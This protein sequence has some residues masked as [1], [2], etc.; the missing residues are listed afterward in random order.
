MKNQRLPLVLL[1]V[2]T[3]PYFF[4]QKKTP[5]Y[6]EYFLEGSYL[7][8]EDE[9]DLALTNFKKAYRLDSS[10]ANINYMMG[11]ACLLSQKNK[12]DAEY[13]L[14]K[15]VLAVSGKYKADDPSEKGAPPLSQFYFG[16]ALHFN[17]KF[18]EAMKA[19]EAFRPSVNPK[20]LEYVKML[21]HAELATT[22]AKDLTNFPLN[23]KIKN[24]GKAVNSP[25]PEYS[26]VLSADERTLIYTTRRP[27]FSPL[28]DR[29][30][31]N[32]ED[33][34]VSY[35]DDEGNWSQPVTLGINTMGHEACINLSADGQT[36]LIY[37]NEAT[38]KNP[39]GNGNIYYAEYNGRDWAELKEFGSDVN[40]I[41][42][43]SHA[44]LSADGNLLF[45]SSERPGGYGGKDIYRCIKL[46]NGKWSKA[47]NMGPR[48]N[49]EFDEDGGFIHPD[50]QTFFY[51]SNGPGSMGGYDILYA[52]L[53]EDNKFGN[54]VNMGYPINT[55]DDDIFFVVSPD[56]KRG[57]FASFK[58][59][60][61]G[62]KDLYEIELDEKREV[63]LAVFKGQI[64]AAPGEALP[65]NIIIQVRDK[66][67]GELTGVYRPRAQN[68]TFT[69]IL[70][71]GHEYSF[72]YQLND[73]EEFYREELYVS[74]EYAYQEYKREVNL[75]PVKI[76][77][78]VKVL[79][80]TVK[81]TI[82]VLDDVLNKK[83]VF[84]ARVLLTDASGGRQVFTSNAKGMTEYA[85]LAVDKAYAISADLE[86]QHSDTLKFT[87]RNSKVAEKLTT[88]IYLNKKQAAQSSSEHVLNLFVQNS[89]TKKG[90][91]HV[92]IRLVDE[93]G[94]KRELSGDSTGRCF[95]I[96]LIAGARYKLLVYK[97]NIAAEEEVF[98]APK[99]AGVI[100]KTLTLNYPSHR[101]EPYLEDKEDDNRQ[102]GE[103]FQF[104]YV[105]GQ[106]VI[107][108][109]ADNYK[110]FIAQVLLRL[111]AGGTVKIEITGS[112]S[113]VPMRATGGNPAL[114][115]RRAEALQYLLEQSLKNSGAD[116]N[117]I[118]LQTKA[119]V[120]GPAYRGD[121][122]VNRKTYEK[123]QFVR[124]QLY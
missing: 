36:L 9:P 81:V 6:R 17:Y 7:L 116:L 8:L 65:D 89:K 37:K 49:T 44:C 47:L 82:Q 38:P 68:G 13:Y 71:P 53:N 43:E 99:K 23:V 70:P 16:K 33:I 27:E 106:S 1:F 30:S 107:D 19:Y 11:I 54:P 25:F 32:F 22:T 113:Q 3:C 51:A 40:S 59:D 50:G 10:S 95:G 98:I 124:A 41:Y 104:H 56:G 96:P 114:A 12:A 62:E 87:A 39:D 121:Y 100:A 4:A 73:G 92:A 111:K 122:L 108:E 110:E 45:F 42:M 80:N 55:T 66:E 91:P 77:G 79:E 85:L 64:L 57:Y 20:D 61:F 123:Y 109:S 94:T 24:L 35:K 88:V 112:A 28:R 117:K 48:I 2:L 72:S 15:S 84:G 93:R 103:K 60:G 21:A 118:V 102:I 119:T 86:D 76:K 101:Q 29:D 58:T 74:N 97:D 120:N 69:T 78:R 105:Y 46:P 31:S 52:T 63:Y 67:T 83:P 34:V 26:P 5:G 115:K 75:E 14:R 18:D 90:V